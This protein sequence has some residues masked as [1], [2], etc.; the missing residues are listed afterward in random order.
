MLTHE[1]AEK[2]ALAWESVR[3]KGVAADVAPLVGCKKRTVHT[4]RKQA[5]KALGRELPALATKADGGKRRGMKLRQALSGHTDDQILS[6]IQKHRTADKAAA[7]LGI[8]RSQVKDR[9]PR[10]AARGYSPKHDMTHTVPDGYLVKG[11]STL[12]DADGNVSA[13]WV[14]SNLDAE[15]QARFREAFIAELA[16]SVKGLGKPVAAPKVS[17]DH[18]L[19]AYAIGD[20]HF[21]MLAL[22]AETLEA[23]FDLKIAEREL[24]G[25]VDYLVS[26]APASRTGLLVDVGDFMHVDNRRQ[27]TPNGGNLLDVDTR[28]QKL[29]SVVVMTF[30]YC[31]ERMLQKHAFVKVIVTPG[32]HNQDSAGWMALTLSM[33]YENE[34]RVEVDTSPSTFFYHRFGK[35]LIGVTHGDRAKF[36]DLPG[37][38]ACDR[39]KDWGETEHRHFF[40]GHIHHTRQQEFRGCFVESFN[41]LAPGDAW[42]AASGYRSKRQMQRLDFH[43]SGGIVSRFFCNLGLLELANAG[44]S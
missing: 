9:L 27:A 14:K 32:N 16:S 18:M 39:A 1:E 34:S 28:Y 42:H 44:E 21:G 24:K 12:Y 15:A 31:I 38:M 36:A 3:G 33:F 43:E 2:F 37:I 29:I 7:A 25:A 8:K 40:T 20:A 30:R 5:E 22:A 4:W 11:V 35:N 10:L 17:E 6:A 41:T 23:D 26:N 13:Q 19:S